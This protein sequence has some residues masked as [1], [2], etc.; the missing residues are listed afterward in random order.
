MPRCSLCFPSPAL[1]SQEF[2]SLADWWFSFTPERKV[3]AAYVPHMHGMVRLVI[4]MVRVGTMVRLVNMGIV[5]NSMAR[6]GTHL[7][8]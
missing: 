3:L 8:A 7:D 1:P 5:L 4:T 6:V 2:F